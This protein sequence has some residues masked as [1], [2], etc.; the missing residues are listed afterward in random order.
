MGVQFW[1]V[2]T[3]LPVRIESWRGSKFEDP[4]LPRRIWSLT[5]SLRCHAEVFGCSD[6]KLMVPPDFI[7]SSFIKSLFLTHSRSS[8]EPAG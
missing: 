4:P 2:K 3:R 1:L 8:F 5:R 7:L 6:E